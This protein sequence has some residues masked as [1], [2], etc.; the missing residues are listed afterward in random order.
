[1]SELFWVKLIITYIG[2][3]LNAIIPIA[4]FLYLKKK[5]YK[6]IFVIF[7][8]AVLGL[9]SFTMYNP[10]SKVLSTMYAPH[11]ISQHQNWYM[12]LIP[13][14]LITTVLSISIPYVVFKY[15]SIKHIIWEDGLAY[16]L[17]GDLI[18]ILF[19]L[20]STPF[21]TVKYVSQIPENMILFRMEME[22]MTARSVIP[23]NFFMYVANF[24]NNIALLFLIITSIK[25]KKLRYL[26]YAFTLG[27][28]QANTLL[29]AF[30]Q[31][32]LV[33]LTIGLVLTTTILS[34]IIFYQS[35]SW[36]K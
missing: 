27:I 16:K 4:I 21:A 36:L 18:G 8:G 15:A 23:L 29:P 5:K 7:I 19:L 3:F 14:S 28:V 24:I 33:W 20:I 10:S 12:F 9:A 26:V 17:G 32:Q 25:T 35:K 34:I 2:I 11:W 31:Q 6:R 1:M 13:F 22:L 30:V